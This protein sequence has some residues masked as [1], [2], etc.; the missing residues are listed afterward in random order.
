MFDRFIEIILAWDLII[1]NV[2]FS[3][4]D[5]IFLFSSIT[6]HKTDVYIVFYIMLLYS[7]SVFRKIIFL[8][9]SNGYNEK[10]FMML[11]YFRILI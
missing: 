9:I 11:I 7:E 5:F 2:F 8:I 4:F 6:Y 1:E 10:A 3:G